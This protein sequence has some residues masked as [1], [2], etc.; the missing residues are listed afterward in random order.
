MRKRFAP[1]L[2]FLMFVLLVGQVLLSPPPCASAGS[3]APAG[4]GFELTTQSVLRADLGAGRI[5]LVRPLPSSGRKIVQTDRHVLVQ[6]A[7]TIQI[8]DTETLTAHHSVRLPGEISDIATSGSLLYAA[9]GRRIHVFCV[10]PD[11]EAAPLRSIVLP[12]QIDLLAAS[13]RLLYA[14]D[15]VVE[16]LYAHVIDVNRPGPLRVE[17]ATWD[18]LEAGL[19]AQAVAD[20][21]Y[22]MITDVRYGLYLAV[23]PARPPLGEVTERNML[24]SN[25][26]PIVEAGGTQGR[27]VSGEFAH[28]FQ[29]YDGIFYGLDGFTNVRL[30]QRPAITPQT[31]ITEVADLGHVSQH[32]RRGI[33]E[34]EGSTLYV[35]GDTALYGFELRKGSRPVAMLRIETGAPIVSFAAGVH[36]P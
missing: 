28:E 16:P 2:I 8:F 32:D 15:A 11:G 23:L 12:K 5:T 35:A 1:A 34:L 22:V 25:M 36:A 6:Q 13:G 9:E 7:D 21:W 27:I 20:R 4:T 18:S 33:I 19:V 29:V 30:F 17:T 14:L 3:P 31:G 26:L 24:P 10:L